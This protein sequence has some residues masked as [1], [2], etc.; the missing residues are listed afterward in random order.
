M[1]LCRS[2]TRRKS[3]DT[4]A[5]VEVRVMKREQ[6]VCRMLMAG[7]ALVP[8]TARAQLSA[9]H[10]RRSRATEARAAWMIVRVTRMDSM[11]RR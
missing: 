4:A 11:F 10:A 7:L 2:W 5:G 3:T 6:S 8:V 9:L 1:S